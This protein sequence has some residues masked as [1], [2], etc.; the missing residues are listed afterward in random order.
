[1]T[2]KEVIERISR[3]IT[4]LEQKASMVKNADSSSITEVINAEGKIELCKEMQM[5]LDTIPIDAAPGCRDEEEYEDPLGSPIE[6]RY[7]VILKAAQ[8]AVGKRLGEGRDRDDVLIRMFAAYR[9]REEG[10]KFESIGE[11]MHRNHSTVVHYVGTR[12]PNM[13]SLPNMYRKELDMLNK[14]NEILDDK[15]RP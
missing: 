3:G 10:Y 2:A 8:Q 4:R 7:G 9:L 12:L 15:G 1:M 11:V 5:L 13:L 14:M 6:K